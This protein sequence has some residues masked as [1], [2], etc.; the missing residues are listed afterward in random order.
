MHSFSPVT[1]LA[2]LCALLLFRGAL[3]E[4]WICYWQPIYEESPATQGYVK[5]CTADKILD[6]GYDHAHYE[7]QGNTSL[8]PADFGYLRRHILE[9]GEPKTSPWPMCCGV[10]TANPLV[11]LY[12][13]PATPCG[14][15]GWAIDWEGDCPG[16][17]WASCNDASSKGDCYYLQSKDDCA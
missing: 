9:L 10:L 4:H 11:P 5:Y 2:Q 3:A 12:T 6:P 16:R 7:C 14:G 15:N 8:R 1:C 17:S 13:G